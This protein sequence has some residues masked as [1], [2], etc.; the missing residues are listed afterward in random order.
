MIHVIASFNYF[1]GASEIKLLNLSNANFDELVFRGGAGDY[2][3]DFSGD[4]DSRSQVSIKSGLSKVTLSV[5][6]DISAEVMVHSGIS[7]VK[8]SESWYQAG[9]SYFHDGDRGQIDIVIEIGAGEL[10]LIEQ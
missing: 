3:L 8:T 6:E 7:D 2:W 1:T 5:P 4:L 10:T 9:T